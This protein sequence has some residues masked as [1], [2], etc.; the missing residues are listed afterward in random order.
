MTTAQAGREQNAKYV[1][2][3]LAV[4]PIAHL[5]IVANPGFRSHDE[6][7]LF[8]SV[9]TRRPID[10]LRPPCSICIDERWAKS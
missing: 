5:G 8:D 4:A 6:W 2:L 10:V 7:Q 9:Q 3:L 1:L